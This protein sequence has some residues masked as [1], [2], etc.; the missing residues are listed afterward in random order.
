MKVLIT[1]ATG[2]LGSSLVSTFRKEFT[3]TITIAK[4]NKADFVCDLT[5]K[6]EVKS[7]LPLINPTIV[8]HCAAFVPKKTEEYNSFILSKNN[9]LMLNNLLFYTDCPIFFISS[10][11]VY[12]NSKKIIRTEDE[13]C[14]PLN[15]YGKS[16]LNCEHLLKNIGRDSLAIRIP[17]LFGGERKTGLVANTLRSFILKKK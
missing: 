3:E 9:I 8:V 2:Y 5:D 13:V 1:G 14:H 12:G 11:T 15:I 10:M 7:I 17:G 6:A 16:K 4:N